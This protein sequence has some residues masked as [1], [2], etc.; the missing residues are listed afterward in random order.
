VRTVPP[1]ART[2]SSKPVRNR[3]AAVYRTPA[4][5]PPQIPSA[6][7]TFSQFPDFRGLGTAAGALSG[8]WWNSFAPRD[9]YGKPGPV[10]RN[11]DIV[12]QR[13]PTFNL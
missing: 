10:I 6:S 4:G 11:I 1:A 2:R 9:R 7:A 12:A 5:R 3:K 13:S 8:T